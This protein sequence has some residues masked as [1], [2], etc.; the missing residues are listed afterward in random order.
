LTRPDVS[1]ALSGWVPPSSTCSHSA[2]QPTATDRTSTR[3]LFSERTALRPPSNASTESDVRQCVEG[4]VLSTLDKTKLDFDD[5][6]R[7][8]LLAHHNSR[9]SCRAAI[10]RHWE[11]LSVEADEALCVAE[12]MTAM[13]YE[14]AHSTLPLH[15]TLPAVWRLLAA[16]QHMGQVAWL[17]GDLVFTPI[18]A[19]GQQL[20]YYWIVLVLQLACILL[21]RWWSTR[22]K[23]VSAASVMLGGVERHR[24]YS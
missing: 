2:Q 13:Q 14:L 5:E 3:R 10:L 8:C 23:G 16:Q 19:R 7:V 1:L 11:R 22:G 24:R 21:Q 12:Q 17:I 4:L 18:A 15:F 20:R 6:L 9:W